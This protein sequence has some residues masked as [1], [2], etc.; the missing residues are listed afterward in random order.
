MWDLY[1]AVAAAFHVLDGE[2]RRGSGFSSF[3]AETIVLWH[4]AAVLQKEDSLEVVG[5]ARGSDQIQCYFKHNSNMS[6][7]KR[8][9]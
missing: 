1:E 5:L 6:F 9:S 8:S 3:D 4:G 7:Q 2:I